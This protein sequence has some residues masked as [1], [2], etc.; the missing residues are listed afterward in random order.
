MGQ[1]GLGRDGK[2]G[3][4]TPG[5][6]PKALDPADELQE[7]LSLF[8]LI[9]WCWGQLTY[10]SAPFTETFTPHSLQGTSLSMMEQHSVGA[11][12]GLSPPISGR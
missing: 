4:V 9:F 11:T 2:G 5:C 3:R 8:C 7:V 12:L 1:E 10:H 6:G